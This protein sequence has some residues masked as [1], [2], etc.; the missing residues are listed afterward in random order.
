MRCGDKEKNL[1]FHIEQQHR[2]QLNSRLQ[3]VD[4]YNTISRVTSFGRARSSADHAAGGKAKSRAGGKAKARD[5]SLRSVISCG[6][7]GHSCVMGN[8]DE[9]Q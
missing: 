4:D 1:R 9:S 2:K 5:T 8:A 7:S 3:R 6:C